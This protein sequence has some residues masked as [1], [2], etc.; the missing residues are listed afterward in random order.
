M[1][2]RHEALGDIAVARVAP[3][4]GRGEKE[5]A[6]VDDK[7]AV[8][9]RPPGGDQ[10]RPKASGEFCLGVSAASGNS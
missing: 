4:A 7:K 8:S 6:V 2:S 9:Q 10:E 5:D 1:G 3:T